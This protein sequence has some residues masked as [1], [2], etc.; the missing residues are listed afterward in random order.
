MKEKQGITKNSDWVYY[1]GFCSI[2]INYFPP[3]RVLCHTPLPLN[4][5]WMNLC[6]NRIGPSQTLFILCLINYLDTR[7]LALSKLKIK[8]EKDFARNGLLMMEKCCTYTHVSA[9]YDSFSDIRRR[10]REKKVMVSSLKRMIDRV[11]GGQ[12]IEFHLTES[13]DRIFRSNA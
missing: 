3:W 7:E 10:T 1:L 8:K 12:L 6:L 9:R 5:P 2:F 11:T 4:P 13:V